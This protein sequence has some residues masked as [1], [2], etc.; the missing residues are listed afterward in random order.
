[1]FS[2]LFVRG[3]S[4]R[5]MCLMLILVIVISVGYI[6]DEAATA[7]TMD[8][9]GWFQTGDLCYID[10]QGY[11]FFVDRIKELIKYK[12]YQVCLKLRNK[13]VSALLQ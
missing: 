7:S 2:F 6:G 5:S 9:Q 11:L 4:L 3:L 13:L 1:M 10:E 12:G 8:S